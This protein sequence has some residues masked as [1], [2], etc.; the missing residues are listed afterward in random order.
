[1]ARIYQLTAALDTL[2]ARC[3][4]DCIGVDTPAHARGGLENRGLNAALRQT[5]SRH[6]PGESR[7]DDG[8][9]GLTARLCTQSRA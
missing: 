7:T 5:L 9:R 4:A 2:A 1:V 6:Q 8:D 3:E